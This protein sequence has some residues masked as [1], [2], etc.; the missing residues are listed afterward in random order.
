[1][2]APYNYIL[3]N[4]P[5]PL[6]AAVSG[7]RL[8]ATIEEIQAA[9][10]QRA[11]QQ[12]AMEAQRQQ[13][14]ALQGALSDFAKNPT[15]DQLLRLA[16]MLPKEV[17]ANVNEAFKQ[18]TEG[19]QKG[20]LNVGA[21]ALAAIQAGQPTVAVDT[22][23]RYGEAAANAGD[24]EGA[25]SFEMFAKLVEANPQTGML[26]MGTMLANLPGGKE[27]IEGIGKAQEQGR[28]TAMFPAK[29][30]KAKGEAEKARVE[31]QF[32]ERMAQ[33]G[34]DE[35]RWNVKNIS[36]QIGDRASRLKLDQ[37]RLELDTV[38]KM[39]E[40]KDRITTLPPALQEKVNAA[41]VDSGAARQQ[42]DRLYSLADRIQKEIGTSWGALGSWAEGWA[43]ISGRQ[44]AVTSLRQE[45]LRLRNEVATG[46][47]PPGAA[48]DK[49]IAL[50]MEGFP[51]PTA[52]PEELGRFL[53][54]MG[55]AQAVKSA[56]EAA[57][58]D[59]MAANRG[60]LSRAQ[61][62]FPVGDFTS[63]PGETWP[64]AAERIAAEVAKRAG[65]Q[66]ARAEIPTSTGQTPLANSVDAQLF[67][68]A[69]AILRGGR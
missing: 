19:Q 28:E 18:R 8:G 41:A 49:D 46:Q 39:A 37:Q 68:Q 52:N 5:N 65:Q 3:P 31:G 44:D 40:L 27:A 48:S 7:L 30:E 20:Y 69:D 55:K 9:R 21:Q 47:L 67:N 15:T 51:P 42:S 25:R 34:L 23:K 12:Q 11:L 53:R 54:G 59:W 56:L 62:A 36:S 1:M 35:R 60:S 24:T 22:L 63:K 14:I 16:P 50:I 17:F 13:Q 6:E 32:A 26:T 58:A 10:Q 33:V 29:L 4:Q 43:K 66:P 61:S 45:Y 57:K 64:Q 2:V 38:T